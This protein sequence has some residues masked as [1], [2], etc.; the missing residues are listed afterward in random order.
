ML[1]TKV[2]LESLSRHCLYMESME[3]MY[4]AIRSMAQVEGIKMPSF[5]EAKTE[6][7]TLRKKI[8]AD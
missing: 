3:E 4:E 7:E 2:L 5:D 8:K 6:V 1:E